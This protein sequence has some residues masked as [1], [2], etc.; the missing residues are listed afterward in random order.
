MISTN[1]IAVATESGSL[2]TENNL[3]GS[4]LTMEV[5]AIN[6]EIATTW[7]RINSETLGKLRPKTTPK[8]IKKGDFLF[9]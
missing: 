2:R 1:I 3:T 5:M 6:T 7:G 9:R 4:I 8:I